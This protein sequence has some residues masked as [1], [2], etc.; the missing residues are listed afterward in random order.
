[1]QLFWASESKFEGN[2]HRI[3][4]QELQRILKTFSGGLILKTG[5]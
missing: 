2:L 1:M 5:I 4:Y 3:G